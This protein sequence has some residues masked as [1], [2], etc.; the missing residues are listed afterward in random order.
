MSENSDFEKYNNIKNELFEFKKLN[1]SRNSDQKKDTVISA[2]KDFSYYFYYYKWHATVISV[3]ILLIFTIVFSIFNKPNYD[4]SI[5]VAGN[6]PFPN[7]YDQIKETFESYMDDF[8]GDGKVLV[9]IIPLVVFDESTTTNPQSNSAI[10]AKLTAN[11]ALSDVMIY[12]V[13]NYVYNR[14]NSEKIFLDLLSEYPEDDNISESRFYIK[15]TNFSKKLNLEALSDE[16]SIIIRSLD[17]LANNSDNKV[18]NY[19]NYNRN[20]LDKII[21]GK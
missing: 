11:L 14:I 2:K 16:F 21:R 1:P 5:I 7:F 15:N 9:E 17:K 6:Y 3:I 10:L 4:A 8:N 19:S 12:L 20:I 18:I 13:D